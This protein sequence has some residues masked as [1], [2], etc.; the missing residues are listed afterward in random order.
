[1]SDNA[2]R[3]G[4]WGQ[5]RRLEFIDFRLLWEGRLNR[6][7]LTN[8]FKISV[9]QASLDLARYQ[10]I[11][12]QNMV[13]DRTQKTYVATEKFE[14]VLNRPDST[15]YL[16]E[17]LWRNAGSVAHSDSFVGW[18]PQVDTL[19]F[20]NRNADINV[21]LA[22]LRAL[23]Q[24]AVVVI[25]YQ[26]MEHPT[27]EDRQVFPRAFAFDGFRWHLR[28][29]CLRSGKDKDFVLGRIYSTGEILPPPSDIP[30][31]SEWNTFVTLVIGPNPKY[32]KARKQAIERDYQM[33]NGQAAIRTRRA[34]LY[35][36][37]KRL[38]LGEPG[39][40]AADSQQIVLLREE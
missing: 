12:P 8:F 29:F 22:L 3:T 20:P 1:M 11:A 39:Q 17:L 28:A 14:P 38:N 27:P 30:E 35:Y 10:E 4:R 6:A 13:Y 21:M 24:R 36:L 15:Q 40:E 9:P 16:N 7:D 33:V 5:E 23:Q 26:S 31:D 25:G 18:A 32:S 34:L 19:P 37:K 2:P